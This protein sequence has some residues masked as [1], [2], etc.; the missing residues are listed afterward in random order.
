MMI[1]IAFGCGTKHE[2]GAYY[3]T[4]C[5]HILVH[6]PPDPKVKKKPKKESKVR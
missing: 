2:D 5:G 4:K 6:I 1:C 3:C